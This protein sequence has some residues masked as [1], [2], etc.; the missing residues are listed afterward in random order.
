[1]FEEDDNIVDAWR[2]WRLQ[3]LITRRADVTFWLS[4]DRIDDRQRR[5][6]E[7]YLERTAPK[8]RTLEQK[9]QTSC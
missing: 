3:A 6:F 7:N 2:R 9:L 8:V 1:M 4:T 5:D